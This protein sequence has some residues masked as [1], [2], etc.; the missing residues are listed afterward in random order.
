MRLLRFDP[1]RVPADR[2]ALHLAGSCGLM[3]VQISAAAGGDRCRPYRKLEEA[4]A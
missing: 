4:E 2:I 3:D 1:E